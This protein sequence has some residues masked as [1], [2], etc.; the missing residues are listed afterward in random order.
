MENIWWNRIRKAEDLIGQISDSVIAGQSVVVA[1]PACIPWPSDMHESVE[2]R[3]REKSP[4]Y[5]LVDLGC[6]DDSPDQLMLDR[7]CKREA[8]ARYRKSV[9]AAKF[10]ATLAESTLHTSYVW[11]RVSSDE[12][13]KSWTAFASEYVQ[14]VPK[15]RYRAAF[16]FETWG[17]KSTSK[18]KGVQVLNWDDSIDPYDIYT[19]CALYSAEI[20]FPARLRPYLVELASH[21]SRYD[22]ELG[23]AVIDEGAAFI[24]DPDSTVRK[25]CDTSVR[26][27]GE[28]FRFSADGDALS[29]LVWEAQLRT[30]FPTIEKF[31]SSYIRSHA[32]A[33]SLCL[34][35]T[36]R[37]GRMIRELNEVELG[38]IIRLVGAGRLSIPSNDY[39]QIDSL[40]RIRNSLAHLT[41]VGFD[42]VCYVLNLRIADREECAALL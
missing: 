31:R 28:A 24:E 21:V 42:D 3:L 30:V 25:I 17:I 1:F 38:A 10:L 12:Q 7:F 29:T 35:A 36:T 2:S 32:E 19:F 14:N 15:G 13:L 23:Q 6:P 41:P 39:E 9:G 33:I 18:A 5:R 20:G 16:I 22:V 8:R 26:S 40:R 34:P 37:D 27:D 4:E 11:I